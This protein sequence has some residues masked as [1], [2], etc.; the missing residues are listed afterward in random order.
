MKLSLLLIP[1]TLVAWLGAAAVFFAMLSEASETPSERDRLGA[2]QNSSL[3]GVDLSFRTRFGSAARML[4][5]VLGR[6]LLVLCV[7]VPPFAILGVMNG[8]FKGPS[9]FS[10]VVS[11]VILLGSLVWALLPFIYLNRACGT[12]FALTW[13]LLAVLHTAVA[14]TRGYGPFAATAWILVS[15]GICA[16]FIVRRLDH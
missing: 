11:W 8:P 1:L 7:L 15:L 10:F 2:K 9:T 16:H 6:T 14:S 3:S 4:F 5:R 12:I 13:L